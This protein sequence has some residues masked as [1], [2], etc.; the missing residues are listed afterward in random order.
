MAL[1]LFSAVAAE[2]ARNR[3]PSQLVEATACAAVRLEL[4]EL[5]NAILLRSADE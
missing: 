4:G 2:N 1:F 3:A 5:V